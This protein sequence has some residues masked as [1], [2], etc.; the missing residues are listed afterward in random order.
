MSVAASSRLGSK[1]WLSQNKMMSEVVETIFDDDDEDEAYD[2]MLE[3]KPS[4]LEVDYDKNLTELYQAITDQNWTL[5]ASISVSDP[6][7]AAIWVVRHY[8]EDDDDNEQRNTTASKNPEEDDE[9]EIMWRFLPL[10]SAC[11]RQPPA[12]TIAALLRAYSDAAKCVDDQGMYALHYACGNQADADVIALLI[13]SFPRAAAIPDP[14]GMLPLHY[15]ACWGPSTVPSVLEAL[16][17]ANPRAANTRDNDGNTPLDLAMDGDY[18]EKTAVAEALRKW[19]RGSKPSS[20]A[21]LSTTYQNRQQNPA[22]TMIQKSSSNDSKKKE[23]TQQLSAMRMMI[24]HSNSH[25][26]DYNDAIVI[27]SDS[28]KTDNVSSSSAP[29]LYQKAK[30]THSVSS[31]NNSVRS[32]PIAL[33]PV[34]ASLAATP[35]LSNNTNPTATN[36]SKQDESSPVVESPNRSIETTPSIATFTGFCAP[37]FSNALCSELSLSRTRDVESVHKSETSSRGILQVENLTDAWDATQIENIQEHG[38]KIEQELQDALQELA[39]VQKELEEKT[40][41]LKIVDNELLTTKSLLEDRTLECNGLRGT[42]GDMMEQHERMKRKTG[43]TAER[44]GTLSIGL[45][46]MM[47]Q[48]N[49]LAMAMKERNDDYRAIFQKRLEL[50]QQLQEMDQEVEHNE[51]KLD[52]SL[53]KQTREL[54]AISAVIKAALD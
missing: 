2:A 38:R 24:S 4:T 53:K 54:E 49:I 23:L 31:K 42:L 43:N 3:V 10:H 48:Q 12:S 33:T 16:L 7:Q 47:D 50:F 39:S 13:N 37:R 21:G 15:A 41:T 45:E 44:L 25:G 18:P 20:A 9:A 14:R 1:D 26:S 5:A 19:I 27:D 22:A 30:S 51:S 28:K 46:S 52:S 34:A 6:I 8:H 11:A 40:N 35:R 29:N 32:L 36:S 17:N